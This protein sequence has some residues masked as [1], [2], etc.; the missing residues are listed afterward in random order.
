VV[1]EQQ[2]AEWFQ[3]HKASL[4]RYAVSRGAAEAAGSAGT[5]AAHVVMDALTVALKKARAIQGV[6]VL[7]GFIETT[8]RGLLANERRIDGGRREIARQNPLT[9]DKRRLADQ[10][11]EVDWEN[12]DELQALADRNLSGRP[13]PPMRP[14]PGRPTRRAPTDEDSDYMR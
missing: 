7:R 5:P 12:D 10:P 14:S 3:L 13:E 9:F 11:E 1:T 4:E 6:G 8:I 2:I